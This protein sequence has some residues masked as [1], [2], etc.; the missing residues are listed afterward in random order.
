MAD[1]VNFIKYIL[2]YGVIAFAALILILSIWPFYSVPYG[3][4]RRCHAL[5]PH[6]WYRE[7]RA[8]HPA[9]MA[10]ASELQC[11]RGAGVYR[12]RGWQ[13]ERHAACEGEHDG[14]LGARSLERARSA[15]R[16]AWALSPLCSRCW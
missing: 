1:K 14:P 4:P 8:R 13:H 11:P 15:G 16:P 3:Q 6:H 5:W 2:R 7:R 9:A 12:E 10:E